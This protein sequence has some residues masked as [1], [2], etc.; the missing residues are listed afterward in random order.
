MNILTAILNF[1]GASVASGITWDVLKESG[2]GFIEKFNRKAKKHG[3]FKDDIECEEFLKKITCESARNV[4][5]PEF[6]L[7]SI[8]SLVADR[9][10]VDEFAKEFISWLKENKDEL[11]KVNILGTQRGSIRIMHQEAHDSSTINNAG[12][13]NNF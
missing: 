6:D 2:K 5:H 4:K 10:D 12:I 11:K 13:I 8:Y 3:W 7:K 9:E 1:V